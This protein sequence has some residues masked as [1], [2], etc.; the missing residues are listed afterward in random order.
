M[1]GFAFGSTATYALR[2]SLNLL[3]KLTQEKF[4][5][6]NPKGFRYRCR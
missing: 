2:R 5:A 1:L 6:G 3:G 4:F